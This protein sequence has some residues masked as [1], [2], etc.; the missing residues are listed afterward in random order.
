MRPPSGRGARA[1]R[2]ETL[3]ARDC[4][5]ITRRPAGCAAL[6]LPARAE[7][8]GPVSQKFSP[9]ASRPAGRLTPLA[10]GPGRS[11]TGPETVTSALAGQ[12][13]AWH[14]L[15][16]PGRRRVASSV[17][18]SPLLPAGQLAASLRSHHA[19]GPWPGR[20]RLG[21]FTPPTDG[22]SPTNLHY[23]RGSQPS[24]RTPADRQVWGTDS[25]TSWRRRDRRSRPAPLGRG[26]C[27]PG[28]DDLAR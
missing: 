23:R 25:D 26:T 18:R 2:R 1:R 9:T 15:F 3:I 6:A 16:L 11:R 27:G 19:Q 4:H 24:R 12:L 14:P 28:P 10:S 17:G 8:R 7:A 13:V 22:Q 21:P 5:L 20:A